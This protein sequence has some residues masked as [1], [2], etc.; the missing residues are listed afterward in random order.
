M[1]P[2][3]DRTMLFT[4]L[5]LTQL[6]HAFDFRSPHKS[7]WHPRSLRNRWLVLGLIGSMTLQCVVIYLPPLRRSSRRR[8][9]PPCT[10]SGSSAPRLWRS[11]SWT[12]ASSWR[13]RVR[14]RAGGDTRGRRLDATLARGRTRRVAGD[15]GADSAGSVSREDFAV[16]A[17]ELRGALTVISGYSDMLRHPL[18][19]DERLAALEGIRRAVGRADALCT[20]VL[21]GRLVG[22]PHCERPRAG[23]AVGA[24]RAR[25]RRAARRDRPHDHRRGARRRGGHR[26]RAGARASAHQPR[27]ERREVLA[28]RDGHQDPRVQ[29]VHARARRDRRASR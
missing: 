20:E 21:S 5:V 26:R 25:R 19:D 15:A 18:H 8:R 2:N 10:G 23:R 6:L 1:S 24:R 4:A 13:P 12:R 17:H 16:F 3:V 7:V 28:R 11:L 9:S 29:R 22:T 14:S 27:H